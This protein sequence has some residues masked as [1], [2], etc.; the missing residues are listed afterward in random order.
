MRDDVRRLDV[1]DHG[2]NITAGL[3]IIGQL[4]IRV[5]SEDHLSP[6]RLRHRCRLAPFLLA[7]GL[8][9]ELWVAAFAGGKVKDYDAVAAAALLKQ[10]RSCAKVHV[11]GMSADREE[12]TLG[13][14]GR[15]RDL[16]K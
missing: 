5:R 4:S 6:E 10:E 14:H 2:G 1:A 12:G 8:S 9:V 15:R 16:Q 13:R 3:L 7:I 11:A